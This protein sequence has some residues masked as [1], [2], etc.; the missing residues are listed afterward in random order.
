[1]SALSK[2]SLNTGE[3][4]VAQGQAVDDRTTARAA[5]APHGQ[6]EA[7]SIEWTVGLLDMSIACW[8]WV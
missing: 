7:D 6:E 2:P 5:D 3:E 1:M 8:P 4:S